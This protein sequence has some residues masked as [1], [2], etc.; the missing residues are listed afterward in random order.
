MKLF[1]WN[2]FTTESYCWLPSSGSKDDFHSNMQFYGQHFSNFKF[3]FTFF[4]SSVQLISIYIPYMENTVHCAHFFYLLLVMYLWKKPNA[5]HHKLQ[6]FY[7][8]AT[9]SCIKLIS[10]LNWMLLESFVAIVPNVTVPKRNET[11]SAIGRIVKLKVFWYFIH[12]LACWIHSLHLLLFSLPTYGR[13]VGRTDRP[14]ACLP[15]N[16]PAAPSVLQMI[17]SYKIIETFQLQMWV[18]V[19]CK[20]H[21]PYSYSTPGIFTGEK[22]SFC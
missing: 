7:W 1:W 3:L 15:T 5:W 14:P 9:R 22:C 6:P 10:H 12:S 17:F 8:N 19:D 13:M 18:W 16:S 20:A 11:K 21:F 2:S 4:S